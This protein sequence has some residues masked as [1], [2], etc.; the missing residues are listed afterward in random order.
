MR[1]RRLPSRKRR[2]AEPWKWGFPIIR[3]MTVSTRD[4]QRLLDVETILRAG[5]RTV[6]DMLWSLFVMLRGD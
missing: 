6:A 5:E 1:P 2:A 3:N 4:Y